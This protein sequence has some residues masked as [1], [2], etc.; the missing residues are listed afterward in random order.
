M[1][2]TYSI[3]KEDFWNYNKHAHYNN[4]KAKRSLVIANI[5]FMISTLGIFYLTNSIISTLIFGIGVLLIQFLIRYPLSK[6]NIFKFAENEK[7]ILDEQT[8]EIGP[9]GVSRVT[10]SDS[11]ISKW[12]AVSK[13]EMTD[14]Y[15]FIFFN[16][17]TAIIIPKRIFKTEDEAIQFY[18]TANNFFETYSN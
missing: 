13:I 18:N 12:T 17:V 8:I 2:I 7:G 3:T 1:K 14:E 11:G 16:K 15:I 9:E 6:R 5:F 10:H 4:P